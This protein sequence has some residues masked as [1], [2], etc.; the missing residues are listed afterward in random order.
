MCFLHCPTSPPQKNHVEAKGIFAT[1]L[2]QQD[3]LRLIDPFVF[4]SLF[5][6]TASLASP[7]DIRK[8]FHQLGNAISQIHALVAS[9]FAVEGVSGELTPK[10]ALI[11]QCWEDRLTVDKALIRVYVLQPLAEVVAKAI[12]SIVSWQ[13]WLSGHT[14]IRFRDDATLIPINIQGDRRVFDQ[15]LSALELNSHH[16]G[17]LRLAFEGRALSTDLAWAELPAGNVALKLGQFKLCTLYVIQTNAGA[18]V[19]DPIVSP[20]QPWGGEDADPEFDYLVDANR[21]GFFHVAEYVC[22]DDQPCQSGKV[23][24]LLQ[25]GTSEW[26]QGAN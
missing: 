22:Q 16:F 1:L 23:L 17:L 25:D 20:A 10:L 9:L 3:E 11:P 6:T 24:L 8:A 14:L 21:S 5:G 19:D 15:M 7:T 2:Q 12:P 18:H 13:P 4:A 26:I